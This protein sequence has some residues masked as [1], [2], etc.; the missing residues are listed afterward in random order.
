MATL[1]GFTQKEAFLHPVASSQH[2]QGAAVWDTNTARTA[3]YLPHASE[4]GRVRIAKKK[5]TSTTLVTGTGPSQS[6]FPEH[7]TLGSAARPQRN[8]LWCAPLT[9][10]CSSSWRGHSVSRSALVQEC[11]SNSQPPSP[12]RTD[13]WWQLSTVET[14]LKMQQSVIGAVS[15]CQRAPPKLWIKKSLHPSSN[16]CFRIWRKKMQ[17]IRLQGSWALNQ[18][19]F[20][21]DYSD[22]KILS[23]PSYTSETLT[24]VTHS[25]KRTIPSPCRNINYLL[26]T[27][28]WLKHRGFATWWQP[29][30]YGRSS[31]NLSFIRPI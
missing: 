9:E 4:R 7:R 22:S 6:H 5:K 11:S 27:P 18:S 23:P 20:H 30:Q 16:T 17:K 29:Q 10:Q 19:P 2:G 13:C 21:T 31:I 26:I 1:G 3:E 25:P 15:Y 28:S 24:P 14:K 8:A 12:S